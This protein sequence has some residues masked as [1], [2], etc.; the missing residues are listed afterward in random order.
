M[1]E[2]DWRIAAAFASGGNPVVFAESSA[3][4]SWQSHS[5]GFVHNRTDNSIDRL[6]RAFFSRHEVHVFVETNMT[7]R[8]HPAR[9]RVAAMI[10]FAAENL[11]FKFLGRWTQRF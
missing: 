2:C 6:C 3:L 7:V 9:N 4:R 10:E 1:R 11:A 8:H 5:H